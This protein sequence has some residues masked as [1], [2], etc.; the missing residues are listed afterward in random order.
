VA[1]G[2]KIIAGGRALEGSRYAF[3]STLLSVSGVAFLASPQ[4]LQAEAFGAVNLVVL[5]EDAA[6]LEAIA[7]CLEG[8][9]TGTVYSDTGGADDA[10]YAQVA[11]V[12]RERVGRL[13]NDKMPTGVAV[14]PAM[15]HGGPYPATGHPGFT[16]VG[17]PASLLRFSALHCYDN[18]RPHRLPSELQDRNPTGTMWR[19]VDSEWTRKDVDA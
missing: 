10:L 18:V 14:T 2:A 8:S 1:H 9:L 17:I 12:L 19:L 5:A 7:R 4:G 11:P 6:Q 15:N 16:A 13:L 3:A